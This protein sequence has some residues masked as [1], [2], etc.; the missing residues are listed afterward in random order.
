MGFARNALLW[1]SENRKLR[2][3]LPRYKFIRRAVSRFMP[4]EELSDAVQAAEKLKEKNITAILTRLGE[5]V[6]D[7][8]ET[9]EVA[10]H[11]L[12]ALPQIQQRR[13]DA[14]ISIKPTQLGLDLNE[15]LCFSNLSAL[16]ERAA[17]FKNWV[18]IDMEQSGYVDRTLALYKKIRQQYSN[19]GVCLQSYLYRTAKDLEALLP[20]SPA[21]RL[22][23]GAYMEP[24]N[25]AYPK[26]ADVDANY[27]A[28]AKMLL[29][30]VKKNGVSAGIATHDNVLIKKVI[31]EAEAQG[32]AKSDYEFQLL[33]GIQSQEQ[34][35]LAGAGYRMRVLISYGS[36][37]FPWYMRRLAERPANVFFVLKN[38]LRG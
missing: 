17:A 12:N 16:V 19:V 7:E 21:I 32:L 2:Q 5:N 14:Y 15:D 27:F 8:A 26:K 33:Y 28:L 3:S 22:V 6:A 37:W 25:I 31:A 23:K 13:L 20:W 35:R 30:N 11:Y 29:A 1:I 36:Y 10:D 4:G 24:A 34:L 38:F 9:R 18:W